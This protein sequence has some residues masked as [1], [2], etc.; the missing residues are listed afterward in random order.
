MGAKY[1][2]YQINIVTGDISYTDTLS[3]DKDNAGFPI[4]N[5]RWQANN[6][7]CFSY[8]SELQNTAKFNAVVKV[9]HCKKT[10][11]RW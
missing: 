3:Y 11:T 6:K 4:I 9:N 10:T 1:R 8:I 5:P 2:R 7:S